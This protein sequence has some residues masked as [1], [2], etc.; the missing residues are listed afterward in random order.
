MKGL[1]LGAGGDIL[2]TMLRALRIGAVICLFLAGLTLAKILLRD[3][4]FTSGGGVIIRKYVSASGSAT[5]FR[6][7]CQLDAGREYDSVYSHHFYDVAKVGD[8]LQFPL[9][10]YKRLV[11]DGKTI[12]RDFSEELI[13]PVVFSLIALLPSIVFVRAGW[14][15][16]RRSF[17]CIAAIIM[18]TVIGFSVAGMFFTPYWNGYFMMPGVII[19]VV[20]AVICS[21]A[22]FL[23]P[24]RP[25]WIKILTLALLVPSL[26]FAVYCVMGLIYPGLL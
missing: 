11:R 23:C 9:E 12:K 17:G 4:S 5:Q 18:T 21:I 25:V 22:F 20:C 13:V 3:N 10:G 24:S 6:L 16:L 19:A 1:I 15:A 2:R 7:D 26:W 14:L 8:H